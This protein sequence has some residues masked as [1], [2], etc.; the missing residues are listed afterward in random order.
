G[1]RP[2]EDLVDLY[3]QTRTALDRHR[4]I[5]EQSSRRRELG[6]VADRRQAAPG[7]GFPDAYQQR[8]KPR[9]VRHQG[10]VGALALGGCEEGIEIWWPPHFDASKLDAKHLCRF[11]QPHSAPALRSRT[12]KRRICRKRVGHA[13]YPRERLLEDLQKLVFVQAQGEPREV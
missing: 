4:A 10:R 3:G 9:D 7:R 11:G 8:T 1:P 12:R 13:R 6:V 2:L 5:R